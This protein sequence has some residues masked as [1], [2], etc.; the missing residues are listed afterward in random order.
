MIK[1]L[2]ISGLSALLVVALA[3]NTACMGRTGKIGKPIA[4][5]HT[6]KLEKLQVGVSTPEDLQELFGKKVSLK[7]SSYGSETWELFDGGNVDVGQVLL[8]GQLSH[9]K[10]QSLVFKFS[11]NRLT[12]WRSVVHPDPE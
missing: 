2:R 11:N 9:D 8:W 10:D 3:G 5:K 7:T 4:Q 6:R 12:S 1:T